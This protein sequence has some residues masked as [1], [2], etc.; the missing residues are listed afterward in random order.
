MVLVAGHYCTVFVACAGLEVSLAKSLSKTQAILVCKS[1]GRDLQ[2]KILNEKAGKELEQ[3][4]MRNNKLMQESEQ[5]S[6]MFEEVMQDIQQKTAELKARDDELTQM[7]L[8]N[9]KLIK[10]RDVLQNKL[11]VAEEQKV[12]AGHERN[13]LKN[14]ISGLEKGTAWKRICASELINLVLVRLGLQLVR[15]GTTAVQVLTLTCQ[16]IWKTLRRSFQHFCQMEIL[17]ENALG[18]TKYFV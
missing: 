2:E 7:R 17:E 13:T 12:D 1:Q 16:Q 6:V 15:V 8:D 10:V 5:H 18:L 11:R 4:Q 14:Q 3:F 9:S